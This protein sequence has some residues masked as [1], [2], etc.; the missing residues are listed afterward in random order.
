MKI[1]TELYCSLASHPLWQQWLKETDE[2]LFGIFI[3][4]FRTSKS[5]SNNAKIMVELLPDIE[6]AGIKDKLMEFLVNN[7]PNAIIRDEN[8]DYIASIERYFTGNTLTYPR[9]TILIAENTEINKLLLKFLDGKIQYEYMLAEGKAYI[10][11]LNAEDIEVQGKIPDTKWL[12]K[13]S[14]PKKPIRN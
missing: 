6:I 8:T 10:E 5:C 7:F 9:R 4:K 12:L 2:N 3:E 14:N 11:Y 13:K 1:K